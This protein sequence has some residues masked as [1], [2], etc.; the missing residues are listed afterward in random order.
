[1]VEFANIADLQSDT[2]AEMEGV[3]LALGGGRFITVRRAGGSNSAYNVAQAKAFEPFKQSHALGTFTEEQA[4]AMLH[5]VY[6]ETI[7]LGWRGFLDSKG[8]EIS[9]SKENLT[10]FFEQ[11]PDV[12]YR[13]KDA[14][15]SMKTFRAAEL[16]ADRVALGNLSSGKENGATKLP[17]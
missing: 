3:D 7:V 14:C 17:N 15:E 16:E 12:F 1:M 11:A 5:G 6:A 13:V 8:K 2:T 10:S 4:V 9:C